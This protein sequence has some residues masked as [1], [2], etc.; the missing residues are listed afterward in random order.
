MG[1][2]IGFNDLNLYLVGYTTARNY[3]VKKKK[4]FHRYSKKQRYLW[5]S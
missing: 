3:D 2:K 4:D 1:K 5:F